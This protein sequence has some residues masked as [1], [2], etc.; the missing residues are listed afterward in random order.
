MLTRLFALGEDKE[1]RNKAQRFAQVL[2]QRKG[3]TEINPFTKSHQTSFTD[4][5]KADLSQ[6]FFIGGSLGK[7]FGEFTARELATHLASAIW[8]PV[9]RMLVW[10]FYF[11]DTDETFTEADLPLMQELALELARNCFE[12]VTVHVVPYKRAMKNEWSALDFSYKPK[13]TLAA[14][15]KRLSSS[16]LPPIQLD[17]RALLPWG[18]AS[19]SEEKKTS[20]FRPTKAREPA[21][22]SPSRRANPYTPSLEKEPK[23]IPP[24]LRVRITTL[25]RVLSAEIQCLQQKA[26]SSCF[27]YFIRY[28]LATKLKKVACLECLLRAETLVQLQEKAKNWSED[29]RVLRG[30]RNTCTQVFGK[31]RVRELLTD[32]L[33][34]A[35]Q[36]E[37]PLLY[38]CY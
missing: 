33:N 20:H 34:D 30:F 8:P 24:Q 38:C 32:I 7:R 22:V 23:D 25:L 16:A 26:A 3:R 37:P 1:L 35:Y 14:R 5:N 4:L 9:D 12:R 31:S 27:S 2:S 13:E 6:L 36:E 17:R 11:I 28:E 10:D 21:A 19:Q 29:K 15:T 18:V